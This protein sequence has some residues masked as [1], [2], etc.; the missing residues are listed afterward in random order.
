[1]EGEHKTAAD[2]YREADEHTRTLKE[3]WRDFLVTGLFVI[4]AAVIIIACLAWFT[5]NNQVRADG[6]SLST[7]GARYSLA[8]TGDQV[9]YP[10]RAEKNDL[11]SL[12]TSDSLLVDLT[13]SF[14]NYGEK[15]TLSP[16]AH[17]QIQF[18]VV[19]Y[20]D[21]LKG[22]K[23][24]LN[25]DFKQPS[26]PVISDQDTLKSLLKGHVLWFRNCS[27]G[28]YSTPISLDG[29][30]FLVSNDKGTPNFD[31]D[32]TLYWV[33]PE[34]FQGYVRVGNANYYQC[35]YAKESEEHENLRDDI[36]ANKASYFYNNGDDVSSA[37]D[38]STDMSSASLKTC[39]TLYNQADE[40]I[41]KSV[42][43]LQVRI[44]SEEATQ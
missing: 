15:Q 14:N 38:V 22:V 2:Y 42:N 26:N 13:N 21:D 6:V 7:A 24:K 10:E 16:G 11:A 9:G 17:G 33:W 19:K 43:Y 3:F 20:A 31:K 41:G 23:I 35:L 32:I 12:D 1:M 25:Y 4:A 39:S 18:K 29:D 5:N 34:Q 36:N 30:G 28:Y 37:P 8:S 44:S 40:A 27:N